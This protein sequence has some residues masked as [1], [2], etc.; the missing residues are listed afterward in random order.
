MSADFPPKK[1]EKDP[2]TSIPGVPYFGCGGGG[3]PRISQTP[4]SF[5]FVTQKFSEVTS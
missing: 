1:P 2:E 3:L 5:H 4:L